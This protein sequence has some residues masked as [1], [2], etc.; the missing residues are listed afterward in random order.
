M[1]E[2]GEI[3]IFGY[4]KT[5]DGLTE[6]ARQKAFDN[7]PKH[8]QGLCFGARLSRRQPRSMVILN[9]GAEINRGFH[10]GNTVGDGLY[11][12]YERPTAESLH[13]G[14]SQNIRLWA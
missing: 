11:A 13:Y 3:G 2:F 1:N 9:H 4:N 10:T 6:M 12:P 14:L 8:W 5:P 7:Q